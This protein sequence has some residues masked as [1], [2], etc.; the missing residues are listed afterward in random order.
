MAKKRS[1]H[2][3]VRDNHAA[4]ARGGPDYRK[5]DSGKGDVPRSYGTKFQ[6]GME[7]VQLA[8]EFGLDSPEYLAGLQR[9]RDAQA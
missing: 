4:A 1:M 8:E 5:H 2:D 7:N 3:R 9:W 6:L